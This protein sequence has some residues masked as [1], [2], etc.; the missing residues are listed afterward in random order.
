M[1]AAEPTAPVRYRVTRTSPSGGRKVYG[2]F[3]DRGVAEMVAQRAAEKHTASVVV[4]EP[5]RGGK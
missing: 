3:S 2:P 1:S 4:V 5:V